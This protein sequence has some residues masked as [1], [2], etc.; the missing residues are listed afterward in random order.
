MPF[1]DLACNA[2]HLGAHGRAERHVVKLT[3]QGAAVDAAHAYRSPGSAPPSGPSTRQP[4]WPVWPRWCGPRSPHGSQGRGQRHAGDERIERTC[5]RTPERRTRRR[6]TE[7]AGSL[8]NGIA[9][10]PGLIDRRDTLAILRR[11]E[12]WRVCAVA[13]RSWDGRAAV[14]TSY[15]RPFPQA[16]TGDHPSRGPPLVRQLPGYVRPVFPRDVPR[17]LGSRTGGGNRQGLWP[18][19]G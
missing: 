9:A 10:R 6:R 8:R 2:C 19:S 11:L 13:R 3:E 14:P 1:E 4:S 18:L 15:G 16:P 12:S 17:G 5:S 7:G